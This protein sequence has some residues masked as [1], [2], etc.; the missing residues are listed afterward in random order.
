MVF[1]WVLS[2]LARALLEGTVNT[3]SGT[4]REAFVHKEGRWDVKRFVDSCKFLQERK[5]IV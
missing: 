3:P 4:T 1:L 5:D 2:S